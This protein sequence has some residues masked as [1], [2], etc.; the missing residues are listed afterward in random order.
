MHYGIQ[1]VHLYLHRGMHALQQHRLHAALHGCKPFDDHQISN[2]T[3]LYAGKVILCGT[4]LSC[5]VG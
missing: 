4:V 5:G 3:T 2:I 1:A